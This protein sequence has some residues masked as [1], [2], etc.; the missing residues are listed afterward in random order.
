[1]KRPKPPAPM[2]K[3][4]TYNK[5]PRPAHAVAA[6]VPVK[7]KRVKPDPNFAQSN[8]LRE[9]RGARQIKTVLNPQ[10]LPHGH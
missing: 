8:D 9:D 2:N 3:I 10:T 4:P 7:P 5:S 1:M 6:V